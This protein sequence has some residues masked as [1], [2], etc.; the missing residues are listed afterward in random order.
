MNGLPASIEVFIKTY[1]LVYPIIGV[2]L[3][4]S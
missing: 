1:N 2:F 3:V 4:C